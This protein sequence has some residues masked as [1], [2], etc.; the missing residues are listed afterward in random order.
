MPFE[1]L[2]VCLGL[3]ISLDPSV[4]FKKIVHERRGGYCFELNELFAV[5]L[6]QVGVTVHWLM[7]RVLYGAAMVRPLSHEVLL[8]EAEEDRWVADAAS[9]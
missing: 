6:E 4:V 3:P 1:N 2:D 7:A 8:V 5:I 9:A